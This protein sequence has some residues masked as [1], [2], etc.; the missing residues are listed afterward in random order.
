MSADTT[1]G[2]TDTPVIPGSSYKVHDPAR[3]Q[4]PIVTP[5]PAGDGTAPPADAVLLFAGQDGSQWVDMAGNPNPWQIVD[6]YMEVVPGTGNIRSKNALGDCQ[7]HLEWAAHVVVKGNGQGRGNS[8]VFL[9]GLYEIQVLDCYNNPTYADGTT[10]AVYGQFPPIV[11]ACRTPGEWQTYDIVWEGPRFAAETLVH[12]ARVTVIH[13]GIVV[14]YA[15]EL[16]GPT[17]HRETATYVPHAPTAPLVLQ[18]HGDRV[19]F[20]NI[21]YRPFEQEV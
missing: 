6:D 15:R 17:K 9:M 10:A 14:Q 12:P 11:N 4:P 7:L 2:Y 18:D 13:N 16:Q 5:A 8:G 3:P 20:R 19:R 21:W 1:L